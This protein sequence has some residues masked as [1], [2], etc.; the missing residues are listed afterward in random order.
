MNSTNTSLPAA[1]SPAEFQAA[2]VE[3]VHQLLDCRAAA[4]FAAGF[5]PGALNIERNDTFG[6]WA[7]LLLHKEKSIL[8]VTD[9]GEETTAAGQLAKA[10]FSNM[11]GYLQ[12][13]F[14]A[15]SNAGAPLDMIIVVEADEL[16]MDLPHDDNLIVVD[17]RTETEFNEGH[18]KEA[19]HLPLQEITDPVLLGNIDDRDNLYIHCSGLHRGVS[20]ASFLKRQGFHNLRVVEGGWNAIKQQKIEVVEQK[21]KLN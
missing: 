17:V 9:A 3:P 15:W 4:D 12:G 2:L 14:P 20:A 5:I 10:G 11:A 8:L 1:L 13:G 21:Q 18:V 19:V 6:N 7:G 16:A